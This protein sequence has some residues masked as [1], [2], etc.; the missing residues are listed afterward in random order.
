MNPTNVLCCTIKQHIGERTVSGSIL[1]PPVIFMSFNV[2]FQVFAFSRFQWRTSSSRIDSSY[3]KAE[4][5]MSL[6]ILVNLEI[7]LMI[8]AINAADTQHFA[9]SKFLWCFAN[10]FQ[11]YSLLNSVK[12][13]RINRSN[14]RND[15][16]FSASKCIARLRFVSFTA[17]RFSIVRTDRYFNFRKYW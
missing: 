14:A 17:F 10:N 11:I 3:F 6:Q 4:A 8:T 1:P 15:P 2:I 13:A 16:L 5:I 12:Y 7:I 9:L